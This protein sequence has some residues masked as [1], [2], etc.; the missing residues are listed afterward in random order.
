MSEAVDIPEQDD[1]PVRP[2]DM[3]KNEIQRV[4]STTQ[5]KQLRNTILLS[6]TYL[7]FGIGTG[8]YPPLLPPEATHHGV[9][10]SYYG[11]MQGLNFLVALLFYPLASKWLPMI[12]CRQSMCMGM[13]VIGGCKI[14]FGTLCLVSTKLSFILLSYAIQI[15][16]GIGI[17]ALIVSTFMVLF[18][19]GSELSYAKK[20]WIIAFLL[21]GIVIGPIYG[22]GIKEVSSF[23]IP[24]YAI[25]VLSILC[26]M[27]TGLLLLE[28]S[29]KLSYEDIPIVSWMKEPRMV[30]YS[31]LIFNNFTYIGFLSVILEPYTR[32]LH[33]EAIFL[34]LLFAIPPSA[35][36]ISAPAWKW[37]T[38]CGFNS[39]ILTSIASLFT[40]A[41]LIMIVPAP[42]TKSNISL[43]NVSVA[44]LLHGL[45]SGC[46]IACILFAADR[47]L[48]TKRSV[49]GINPQQSINI[50]TMFLFGTLIGY[51]V[52]CLVAGLMF[53][54]LGIEPITYVFYAWEI[55]AALNAFIIAFQRNYR[56][57][58]P[59]SEPE[60][61]Q[62]ILAATEK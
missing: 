56:A 61:R 21:L 26:G 23:D 39:L 59:R 4:N 22:E 52:G 11:P 15:A 10:S 50:F 60:E 40:F 51:F 16:E 32:Q 2:L 29:T 19:Q 28:P 24:F 3:R 8:I 62:P 53:D 35:C 44:L 13:I 18:S 36:G 9:S 43:V 31:Y 6:F 14:L 5:K 20:V 38:K 58:R 37:L 49:N 45:G 48:K 54:A 12:T 46:K 17:S 1:Y 57:P 55:A 7:I 42:F 47:D 34:G 41:S 25:G 27:L 33:L 30:N